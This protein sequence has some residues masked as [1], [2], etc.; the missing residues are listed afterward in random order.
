M[1][2][3]KMWAIIACAVSLAVCVG[4]ASLAWYNTTI[5]K[6]AIEAGLHQEVVGEQTIWA[7]KK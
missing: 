4:S 6:A 1:S 3:Y 7:P 2:E 5:D